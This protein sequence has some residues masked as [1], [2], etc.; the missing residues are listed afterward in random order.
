VLAAFVIFWASQPAATPTPAAQPEPSTAWRSLFDGESLAGWEIT[1]FGGEGDVHV[2]SGALVL[3]QGSDLTGVHTHREIPNI[4]YEVELDAM[5][6]DGID[7][8][9]GLTFP[10]GDDPCSLII[11]GWSGGVCGLSSLDGADASEN[12]TTTYK[13]FENGKWYR[14][15][16]RVEQHRIRAWIDDEEIVDVDTTGRKLS[17][18][19]EVEASRPF[20][21]ASWQTTAALRDIRIRKLSAVELAES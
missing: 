18:R 14:I 4:D 13:Q 11:G 15:R 7:F 5:R 2:D 17:V 8:F 19:I 10:V 16:L 1:N 20:G 9:C 21:F 6:V 12:E 3:E